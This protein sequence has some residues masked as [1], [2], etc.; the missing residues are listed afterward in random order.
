MIEHFAIIAVVT[1]LLGTTSIVV[2]THGR[3]LQARIIPNHVVSTLVGHAV[4]IEQLPL[5]TEWY[6]VADL[7]V[8]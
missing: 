3:F 6:V 2:V 5:S 4:I 1:A 8:P 7:S